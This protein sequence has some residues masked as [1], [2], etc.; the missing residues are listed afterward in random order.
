MYAKKVKVLFFSRTAKV[1]L[2][3]CRIPHLHKDGEGESSD[4]GSDS[5][6][7][8]GSRR[9]EW[10]ESHTCPKSNK[11]Y[12]FDDLTNKN[13]VKVIF[14]DN[15]NQNTIQLKWHNHTD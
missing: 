10:S 1:T 7:I 2:D 14:V 3:C 13:C 6:I 8:S 4:S 5:D 12:E 11:N 15:R 9:R